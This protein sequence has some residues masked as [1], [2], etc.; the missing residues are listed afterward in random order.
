MHV[1]Q[2]DWAAAMRVADQY[3]RE[4]KLEVMLAQAND[5]VES[6]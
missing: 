2:R 1:H 4:G 6:G 3:D 5:I